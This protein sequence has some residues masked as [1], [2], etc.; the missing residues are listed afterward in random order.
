MPV[1]H[2]KRLVRIIRS[3]LTQLPKCV[4]GNDRGSVAFYGIQRIPVMN[5]NGRVIAPLPDEPVEFIKAPRDGLQVMLTN[6]GGAVARLVQ[7]FGEGPLVRIERAQVIDLAV[8]VAVLPRHDGGAAGGTNRVGYEAVPEEHSFFSNPIQVRRFDQLIR[9]S[10]NS[11]LGMIIRHDEEDIWPGSWLV[12]N[13]ILGAV[14][15]AKQD[16]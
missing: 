3:H 4:V 13:I 14:A 11:T 1:E 7:F 2:H 6:Q 16:Q 10:R 12:C 8:K 15:G 9:V 5:K